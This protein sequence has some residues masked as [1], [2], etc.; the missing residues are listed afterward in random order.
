MGE[1]VKEKELSNRRKDKLSY[2]LHTANLSTGFSKMG[3][4]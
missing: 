1:R 2:L 3:T 4:R